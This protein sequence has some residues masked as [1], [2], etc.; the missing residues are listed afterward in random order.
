MTDVLER[1]LHLEEPD[2]HEHHGPSGLL[3]WLTTTDHKVIGLS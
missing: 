1:P 3:K 2:H